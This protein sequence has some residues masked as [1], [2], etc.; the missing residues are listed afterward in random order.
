[1]IVRVSCSERCIARVAGTYAKRRIRP[2]Q[3]VLEP[4]RVAR[5]RLPLGARAAKG[6]GRRVARLVVVATDGSGNTST[7]RVSARVLTRR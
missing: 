7:R 4:G 5:L 2:A 6:A 3:V 1:L